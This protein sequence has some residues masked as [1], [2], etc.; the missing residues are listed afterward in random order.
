MKYDK[1]KVYGS[2]ELMVNICVLGKMKIAALI[3]IKNL[4]FKHSSDALE[5]FVLFF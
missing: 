4:L 1:K 5:F 2:L 3:N